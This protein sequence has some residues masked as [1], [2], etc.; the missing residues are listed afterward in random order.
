M[1]TL[2]RNAEMLHLVKPDPSM[3]DEDATIEYM[4]KNL[5]IIGDKQSC[6]EQLEQLWDITGGFG[7]LLMIKQDF[8]DVDRWYR[9]M[10]TLAK[11]IIPVMPTVEST[12]VG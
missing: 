4:L 12:V 8:D 1:L 2:L 5:C 7:T 11:E 10:R 3:P 6:I 9:C